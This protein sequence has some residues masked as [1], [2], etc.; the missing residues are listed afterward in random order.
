MSFPEYT[1]VRYSK[2]SLVEVICQVRFAP[3]LRIDAR[4]PDMYQDAIRSM[5]PLFEEIREGSLVPGDIEKDIP[6]EIRQLLPGLDTKRMYDF[7]SMDGNWTI[8]LSRDFIALTAT[9][10]T[11]WEEFLD[12]FHKPFNS[13]IRIYRPTRFTRLGLR[14]QNVITRSALGLDNTPWAELINPRLAGALADDL[15][16]PNIK[17]CGQLLQIDLPETKC[18][19][20]IRH[21]FAVAQGSEETS[22]LIDSDFYETDIKENTHV[23]RRLSEFN[24]QS[25]RLFR[26]GISSRLH[27]AMEPAPIA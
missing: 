9:K 23:I 7:K 21:G 27:E 25:G 10:Y 5:F 8:R 14:Y 4:I 11:L 22:Y 16:G 12:Y 19:V 13:L 17:S 3:I 20:N 18:S 24:R 26:W 2:S 1:R 6:R 15:I